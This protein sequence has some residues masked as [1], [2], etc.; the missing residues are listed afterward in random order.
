MISGHE[1]E[2]VRL[3]A[4]AHGMVVAQGA[5]R[6]GADHL[7]EGYVELL[8]GDYGFIGYRR[9]DDRGAPYLHTIAL[10]DIAWNEATAASYAEHLVRGLEFRNLSTL[11]GLVLREARLLIA[12]DAPNHPCAGGIPEGHPPLTRFLGIPVHSDGTMIAMVGIANYSARLAHEE[13]EELALLIERLTAMVLSTADIHASKERLLDTRSRSRMRMFEQVLGGF[14]H[15]LNNELMVLTQGASMLSAP[16]GLPAIELK[17]V[18]SDVRG[19]GDAI[20]ALVRDLQSFERVTKET[21][22][23]HDA[24]GALHALLGSTARIVSLITLLPCELDDGALPS[25]V[26][27]ALP[28][29][30]AVSW[31]LEAALLVADST[32]TPRPARIRALKPVRQADDDE[33]ILT[34][35]VTSAISRPV[36]RD[37]LSALSGEC[38]AWGARLAP[39]PDGLRMSLP[40]L[41]DERG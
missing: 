4:E 29:G 22:P 27:L 11:F 25:H 8:G 14:A 24:H 10:S 40:L 7:L 21:P 32:S 2:L 23:G 6:E 37:G 12:H 1:R 31:L 13:I 16:S 41:A 28:G 38:A 17:E 39:L 18:A 5:F 15:A 36:T 26:Q 3:A 35:L 30:L 33:C 9:F 20:A 34:I 19:A